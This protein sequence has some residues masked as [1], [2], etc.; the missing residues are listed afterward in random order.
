MV[1]P[2]T[3]LP[4]S[5][6][7]IVTVL[8]T[9]RRLMTTNANNTA[10]FTYDGA[11]T[12]LSMGYNGITTNYLQDSSAGLPVVLQET[13]L[14]TQ[15]SSS[16]LYPLGS[17]SP[18]FVSSRNK[19]NGGGGGN[20]D[21]W[22]H[23]DGEGSVRALTNASGTAINTYSYSAF[24]STTAQTGNAATASANSHGFAGEQLDPTGLYFN[25][26][27]YYNPS[28]GRFIGRDTLA[29]TPNDPI[30]MNRFIFGA[31]NPALNTDPSGNNYIREDDDGNGSHSSSSNS[32]STSNSTTQA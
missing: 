3:T 13:W 29:G 19:P 31:D 16:Y 15:T 12:R 28:L 24:G 27:R 2:P 23:A 6:T 17:T 1:T 9:G 25:R 14:T 20:N 7:T 26:A 32:D 21:L 18:L 10:S 8:P 5:P 22:Y 30:S 4:R 11:N